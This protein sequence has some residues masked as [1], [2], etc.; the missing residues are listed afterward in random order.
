MMAIT[1]TREMWLAAL[2]DA[3]EV[4]D[5]DPAV[6]TLSELA[7]LK[8]ISPRAMAYHTPAMVRRGLLVRTKKRA[9]TAAGYARTVPAYRLVVPTS[10]TSV[11]KTRT[12]R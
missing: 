5:T 1:I 7:A 11:P 3:G 10:G 6:L 9:R 2:E 12:R 8:G 4:E